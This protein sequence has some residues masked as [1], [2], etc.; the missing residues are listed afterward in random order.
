MVRVDGVNLD[1]QPELG[2]L[3]FDDVHVSPVNGTHTARGRMS[4]WLHLIRDQHG[5]L[6]GGCETCLLGKFGD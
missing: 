1:I 6:C 2:A 4:I 3:R 5:L